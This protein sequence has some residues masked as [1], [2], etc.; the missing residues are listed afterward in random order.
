MRLQFSDKTRV[1]K[2]Y[3]NT[4]FESWSFNAL[5]RVIRDFKTAGLNID[6]ADWDK[7]RGINLE[8]IFRFDIAKDDYWGWGS[9][10]SESSIKNAV[11]IL[12]ILEESFL[13]HWEATIKIYSPKK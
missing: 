8:F 4:N 12:R 2:L 11:N 13:N 9:P 7:A 1:Q 6:W 10:L 5:S 3:K